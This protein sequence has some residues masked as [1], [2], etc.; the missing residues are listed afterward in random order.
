MVLSTEI[1]I[2]ADE[3]QQLP[4]GP[5]YYQLI[6]GRLFMT[7]S[8][9]TYHQKILGNLYL[10]LAPFVNKSELGEVY[11]APLDVRLSEIDVFQPDLIFV[12]RERLQIIGES[13]L[14]G[15]PDLAVEILSHQPSES[16]EM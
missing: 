12:S 6:G 10:V 15:A 16:T 11:L 2:T 3:Y 4:E 14:E 9:T 7:P 5:P 13:G 8:P 1:Q